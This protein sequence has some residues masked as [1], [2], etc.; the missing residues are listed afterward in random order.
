[1]SGRMG[2]MKNTSARFV[3]SL[4]SLLFVP[5][6]IVVTIGLTSPAEGARREQD[7]PA[8]VRIHFVREPT[9]SAKV[10]SES[11][12]VQLASSSNTLR[13]PSFHSINGV[14]RRSRV[15]PRYFTDNTG[16]AIYLTGS[17]TWNTLQD[18]ATS[19]PF[20][21]TG[22]LNF[23]RA[24]NHNYLRFWN[25]ESWT[26]GHQQ[27]GA[28]MANRAAGK[29]NDG[30][31]KFDLDQFNQAYFDRLRQRVILAGQKGI[32]VGFC[33]FNGWAVR[34]NGEG[35]PGRI[36]PSIRPTTSMGQRRH[37]Q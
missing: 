25:L 2:V 36:M 14:L 20:D 11:L 34:D 31:P 26:D 9:S 4:L 32:Y 24:K 27:T 8:S 5:L 19:T 3:V 7:S 30:Q 22:W 13:A 17:H 37:E 28:S 18:G 15:N 12:R 21:Y 16:R 33:F 1:M 10:P 23:M 35:N 29:A 6:L